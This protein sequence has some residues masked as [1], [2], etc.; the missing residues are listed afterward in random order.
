[1]PLTF[2]KPAIHFTC[3]CWRLI[4]A[5]RLVAITPEGDL[6]IPTMSPGRSEIMSLGVPT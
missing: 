4:F 3:E 2:S 5:D 1:L 6:L